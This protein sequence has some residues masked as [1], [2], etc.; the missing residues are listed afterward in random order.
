SLISKET[1][2]ELFGVDTY[3]KSDEKEVIVE[4]EKEAFKPQP[5]IDSSRVLPPWM[6]TRTVEQDHDFEDDVKIETHQREDTEKGI[7]IKA[8]FGADAYEVEESDYKEP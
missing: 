6:K 3:K 7:K 8:N 1:R 4:E 2:K 5:V